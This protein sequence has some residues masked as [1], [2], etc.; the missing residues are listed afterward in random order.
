M[1][2]LPY[3]D[4]DAS[5]RGLAG[6]AEGFGRH[7]IGGLHGAVYHVT[8]LADDGCGSLREGCRRSEPL[9]IVFEVSGTIHLSSGLRVSSYK[10]IDGRGQRVKLAGKGLQLRECEHVIIC[11]L[12]LEGGRGH[13]VDAIQIKPNSRHIWIDR[14]SLRG[15]YDGLIDITCG[16]TDITVSRCHFSMHDKTI[17]IGASSCH[18]NDRCIRVTIHHCFFDGTRQRH[19]RVRFGKVH[20][21]NNY[22]RNWGI[23][24]VC[25]CVESQLV[26]QCNIYEA[27]EK[28]MV[29]KYLSEKAEDKEECSCGWIRSEGDLFLNG[30]KP[31]LQTTAEVQSVFNVQEYYESCSVEPA[32]VDLMEVLQVCT[33]WQS[34]PRP[35]ESFSNA[36]NTI[37]V[38]CI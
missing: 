4:V 15:F 6:Q 32:S 24:A 30:A 38:N 7:A 1:L 11:N 9:W 18:I 23:Y 27:G 34:T 3:P 17:L 16:S 35:S 28:K 20:L 19:P 5:L 22:T 26:S 33:G 25:A 21:Y 13:D 29:F 2:S 12:E 37:C 31:C 36:E 14:C 10:T 8:T